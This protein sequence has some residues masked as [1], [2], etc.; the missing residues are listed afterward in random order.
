MKKYICLVIGIIAMVQLSAQEA[1]E[2]QKGFQ[3]EKLFAGGNF[4]LSFGDY[5]IINISPQLGYRFNPYLAAGIGLNGQYVSIKDR[6]NGSDYSKTSQGVMGFNVF[7]RVYPVQWF[8]LQL[9]PEVNYLF[10]KQI[11]YG[12]PRQEYK[13][14]ATIAPSLLAG[15]GLV[16]PGGRGAFIISAFYDVLQNQNSP[17]GKKPIINFTYNVGL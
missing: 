2:E 3:K 15:A 8:M 1:G 4:G 16:F 17:Y 9:Q 13:L 14:D 11:Y 5:T 10:G 12:P 7:G 6:Y